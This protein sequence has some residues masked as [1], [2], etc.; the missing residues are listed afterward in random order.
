MKAADESQFN[1][2][3]IFYVTFV[4]SVLV[5]VFAPTLRGPRSGQSR[6]FLGQIQVATIVISLVHL[7]RQRHSVQQRAGA[8]TF[9]TSFKKAAEFDSSRILRVIPELRDEI[10]QRINAQLPS[11]K[12][13]DSAKMSP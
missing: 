9:G 4:A 7:A 1:L 13:G 6:R 2:R 11:P 8:K 10:L 3:S 5:A 12:L